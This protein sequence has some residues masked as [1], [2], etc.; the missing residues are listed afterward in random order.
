MV[1]L[2]TASTPT[3]TAPPPQAP[4]GRSGPPIFTP[5]S[6]KA[7]LTV[8]ALVAVG[9]VLWFLVPVPESLSAWQVD[10]KPTGVK[11]WH[12]FIVFVL[13]ILGL[14]LQPFPL[15]VMALLGLSVAV[16][17]GSITVAQGL[18]GFSNAVM[19]MIV[20]AFFVSRAIIKSGLGR[21]IA[22]FFVAKLGKNS[23]GV[24][25]GLGLTDLALAPATPSAMARGGAIVLPILR[26]VSSTYGSEPRTPTAG[27]IGKF[28]TFTA[29]H[30]NSATGAL[31][32][33]AMA[34]N[35]LM[36]GFASDFGLQISW[37]DWF[38]YA[39]GP[40]V[41][42][43]IATPLL[44][45]VICPPEVKHTPEVAA[46]AGMK[47]RALGPI[48]RHEGIVV[49]V[50]GLLILL[51]T[52]G[53]AMLGISA[54]TTTIVGVVVLLLTG[55]LTLDDVTGEK[56]AWDTL[57]WF[58]IVL[59]LA[60]FLNS[61]GFIPWFSGLVAQGL[62]GL[63]WVVAFIVLVLVYFYSHY[64]F[65]S[66]TSHVAAM[67]AAF[68]GTA[69][70]VGVPPLL[71]AMVLGFLSSYFSTLT[72]YG[73]A[74]PTL[75]FAQGFFTVREWWTKNLIMSIPNLLIWVGLGS[76]WMKLLGAW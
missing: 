65:A 57:I 6:A 48:S 71:A 8:A 17:T 67:Y 42:A 69:V 10:G 9:L 39:A 60:N 76:L 40:G 21:R 64:F 28:L 61:L 56:S 23:L 47:L 37:V 30:F 41:V 1:N 59:T 52:A 27:R 24:A 51:W 46:D 38:L 72:H 43:L 73:G 14:I 35:P 2:A 4:A 36:V 16:L 29:A 3:Q 11:A 15:S 54:T 31:F 50:I 34:A 75:L 32:L 55:A 26:A 25:Y 53:D 74:A 19:W 62:G 22:Y 58:A 18:S 7:V 45:Y 66:L 5:P 63:N 12:L 13:T 70:A 68:L 33:T 44:A 49:A 20:M